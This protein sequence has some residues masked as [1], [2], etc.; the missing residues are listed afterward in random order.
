MAEDNKHKALVIGGGIAGMQAA[1]DMAEAGVF[2]YLV[3]RDEELGGRTRQLSRT[4]KTHECKADGCCI[5][6]CWECIFTPKLEELHQNENIE[7][8]LGSEVS[9]ITG[10]AGDFQ[11]IVEKNGEKRNIGVNAVVVTTGSKTFDPGNISAYGHGWYK[12][13][14]T[15]L[16]LEKRLVSQ[17]EDGEGWKLTRPSNDKTPKVINFFLC[18]GSRDTAW[19]NQ[20][21]SVVCCTYAI[22][23]AKEIKR[24]L[25]DAQVYVHYMD[26]RASY[27]GFEE[28][29]KEAQEMGINFVRARPAKVYEDKDRLVV[30]TEDMDLDEVLEIQ[31]DLV[32]LC[33]G[34]EPHTGT[35]NIAKMLDLPIQEN[36]FI[37]NGG[38]GLWEAAPGIA[39]AGCALGPK[40]IRYS[41]ED[42]KRAA[43]DVVEYLQGV[44]RK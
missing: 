23:Q 21:C 9:D 35:D 6:Y 8:I 42:A 26:L 20:H 34:Q 2:T 19:G 31:S 28:H 29:Y 16:E 38:D 24:H 43:E 33:V 14:L 37:G 5:D 13:V 40:G 7:I 27:R 25:P 22:G 44:D 12:D 17:R 1:M 4:F 41:V 11:V 30:Q 10:K 3:E 32:V 39:V 18:V 36:G 15:F